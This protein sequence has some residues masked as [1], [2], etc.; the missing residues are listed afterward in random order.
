LATA[1]VTA[2]ATRWQ[3]TQRG[4]PVFINFYSVHRFSLACNNQTTLDSKP[5]QS[6]PEIL[7]QE[8]QVESQAK[9]N[10]YFTNNKLLI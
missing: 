10:I 6:M 5:L 8:L 7:Q 9:Y 1:L 3:E 4:D 2:K